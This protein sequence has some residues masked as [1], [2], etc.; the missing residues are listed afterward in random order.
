LEQIMTSKDNRLAE[1]DELRRQ[2]EEIARVKAAQSPKNFDALSLEETRQALH[3]L[4]A[5]KIELERQNEE[6]RR[7]QTELEATQSHYLNLYD[8]APVGYCTIGENGLILD[9]NLTAVTMMG[10]ARDVLVEQPF[11]QFILPADQDVHYLHRKKLFE[12][13][14]PQTCELRLVK[15][16]GTAFWA[17]LEGTAAQ[18]ANGAPACRVVMSDI[19]ERKR[20]EDMHREMEALLTAQFNEI[21]QINESLEQRVEE[22]TQ[23]VEHLANE[24][25][26]ILSTMPIGASFL[27]DRKVQ[28]ANPA[29]DLIFGYEVGT[30]IGMDTSTFYPDSETYERVGKDAYEA[31][32]GGGIFTVESVM[33]RKDG[34]QIWCNIV[35]RAVNAE[36]PGDGSIWMVQDISERKQAEEERRESEEK[37]R[38]LFNN[39][40][41][42]IYVVDEDARMLAVNP[43]ACEQLGYTEAE[44]M[45]MTIDLL[46]SPEQARYIPERIARLMEQGYLMFET[47]LQRKDGSPVS[48]E[49][50]ARKIN[51]NGRPAIMS[52][53]RDITERKQAEQMLL[54]SNRRLREATEEAK[55]ANRAKSDFLSR[56]SHELRTPMNAIIGFTQ[57]LEDDRNHSL[58]DDQQ[59]SLHEI[60]KAGNHLLELINEVLDLSK[61]ESGKLE[62]S[63]ET[64]E[65]GELCLECVSL[66]K[67]LAEQHAISV[68]YAAGE[69][70]R[71]M[72]DRTR[73][74]QVLLNL[75]SN[76]IK[77]NRERGTV[78]VGYET[79]ASNRIRIWVS[80]TGPGIDPHFMPRLFE[81]FERAARDDSQ[82]EGTGIGLAL[83]KRLTEAMNGT[84]GVENNPGSGSLF[85][86]EL[87]QAEWLDESDVLPNTPAGPL[88]QSTAGE[89]RVLYIEDNPANLRLVKKILSSLGGVTLLMAESAETG[90]ELVKTGRPHLIL[91][92]INLPGI[93]GFEALASLRGN[94]E[95]RDIPVVAVTASAMPDQL[96]R[97]KKAGFDDCLTKPINLHRFVVVV[98]ALLEK[99]VPEHTHD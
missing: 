65:P 74:R 96:N 29:F 62:L 71:V 66:L 4:M 6:L 59:D 23:Q 45:S 58:S 54:E 56:M 33:K 47:V 14:G 41:D 99:T 73:L 92:D 55:S 2:A 88:S 16:D 64:L 48:T 94:P 69:P 8:M 43:L 87:S 80:N 3:E 35:G 76:G 24:Q 25:R 82:I 84:I 91:M 32:V 30:T 37:Y 50:S 60:N 10:T 72:A 42:A 95:T 9:A 53:C 52:I 5:Q 61:I 31:T 36:K 49:V 1:S 75:I 70:V 79:T 89:R 38:L 34:F 22:R 81:P 90:M 78:Q 12:S 97:I 98:D 46:D 83:A 20:A 44:L 26:F 51:W 21:R 68:A 93:N 17:R 27:K 15:K 63:L 28:A 77:Y 85:W 57:L 86:I 18:D 13:G 7:V 19:T 39:A 11:T 67:P 40:A